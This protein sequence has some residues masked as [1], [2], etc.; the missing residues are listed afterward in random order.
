MLFRSV[1]PD[2]LTP[3]ALAERDRGFRYDLTM[4]ASVNGQEISR[5]NAADMHWTFAELIARASRNVTLLPGDLIGSGT[6]GTGCL[7]EFPAGTYPWLQPGDRVTL[8]VDELG[9]LETT[10]AASD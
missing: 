2:A 10:I 7:T 5:G 3:R 8:N 6:V 9:T 4:T 1:T